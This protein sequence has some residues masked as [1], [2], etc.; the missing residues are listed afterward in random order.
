PTLAPGR[1]FDHRANL[2]GREAELGNVIAALTTAPETKLLVHTAPAGAGKSR[3]ALETHR[4]ASKS[5][6]SGPQV[7]AR[8][9]SRVLDDDALSRLPPGA[10]VLLVEDAHRDVDGLAAVLQYARRR[11][12]VRVLVTARG[13]DVPVLAAA[14]QAQ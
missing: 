14:A 11:S 6:E 9:E 5:T 4:R 3:L 10:L 7:M 8:V 1:R 13:S 2:I 12:D